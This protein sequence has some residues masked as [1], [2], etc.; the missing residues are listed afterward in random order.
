M[1]IHFDKMNL[2]KTPLRVHPIDLT[3]FNIF[4]LNIL[5]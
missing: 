4:A 3:H 2:Y 1:H 5:S